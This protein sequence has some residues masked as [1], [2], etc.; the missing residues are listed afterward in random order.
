MTR[1]PESPRRRGALPD[2]EGTRFVLAAPNAERVELCLFGTLESTEAER[3]VE[4]ER[5]SGGEL[6]SV[7]APGIGP[8]ATYGY[9]V[10]GPFS[11]ATGDRF[12]PSK[13]LVDPAARRVSGAVVWAEDLIRQ[14]ADSSAVVPRSVVVA[15][16]SPMPERGPAEIP[17]RETVIYECHVRGAT[18]LHPD[19]PPDER[20]TYRGLA[21]PAFVE[22][23]LRLGVTTVELMPVHHFTAERHLAIAGR[24]NYWGY[25]PLA[26]HAPHAGYATAGGDPVAEFRSMVDALHDAGLEVIVDVVFN[27]TCEGDHH[28]PTLS[29]RGIDNRAH[30]RVDPEDR[31]RYV[32]MTGTGHTLDF[33]NPL[34]VDL[35]LDA[36]RCWATELGVDGFRFDL[37][38]ALG[39]DW[40]G[41][42]GPSSPLLPGGWP[43][44]PAARST[45]KLDRGTL[46]PRSR[47][48]PPG[49]VPLSLPG[50]ERPLPGSSSGPSGEGM[51]A[52]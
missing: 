24:T 29:L 27:H 44:D 3:R 30:Y 28:G 15:A 50:M 42:S 12:D 11:P 16:R 10:H 40:P 18:K 43:K 21:S 36:L 31:S 4:L 2:A 52:S 7:H 49:A 5:G 17:W 32:D 34:V 51:P 46:G 45:C 20:G 38:P 6:W 48:L 35:A 9:R 47:W 25:A 33:G 39:R 23:L 41:R 37:A 8:G 22:H 26:F 19:V 1:N 14:G 13:L